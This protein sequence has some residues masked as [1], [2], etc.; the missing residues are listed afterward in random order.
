MFRSVLLLALTLTCLSAAPLDLRAEEEPPRPPPPPPVRPPSQDHSGDRESSTWIELPSGSRVAV[1]KGVEFKGVR[2]HLALTW[3][4]VAVDVVSGKVLW[5]RNTSAFWNE[6]GF[7]EVETK[8][9]KTVE[10]VEL[11]PGRRARRGSHLRQYHDLRS[12]EKL[13]VPGGPDAPSGELFVPR[14]A[15]EGEQTNVDKPFTLLVTSAKDWA[16]V[17]EHVWGPEP[18]QA[19]DAVDFEK[20]V[21]LLVSSGNGWNC[22]AIFCAG[23]WEDEK[24]VLIRT[25]RRCYQTMNGGNKTRPWGAFVLPRRENTAYVVEL[26][27]QNLIGGPALWKEKW[28]T[29]AL[30]KAGTAAEMLPPRAKEP[31]AGWDR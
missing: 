27:V 5:D 3:H 9:G 29:D 10:A 1:G 14:H 15:W 12:G 30:P 16:A 7:K 22:S 8:D 17:R 11:R 21:V 31:H 20:E 18:Q 13:E 24:R 23:C 25:D 28:R 2:I 6:V 4:L 19:K 26:D